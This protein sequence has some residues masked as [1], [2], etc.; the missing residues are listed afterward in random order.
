MVGNVPALKN[1]P[2]IIFNKKKR[3]HIDPQDESTENQYGE[4]RREHHVRD[5]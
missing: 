2:H 1:R 5:T 3:Q 4:I